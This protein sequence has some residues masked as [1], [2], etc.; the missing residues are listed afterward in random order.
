M[1]PSEVFIESLTIRDSLKNTQ[2]DNTNTIDNQLLP[3]LPFRISNN[4]KLIILGQDPAV[5]NAKSRHSIEYTLNLDKNGALKS[6]IEYICA[7]LS[8]SLENIY[9]TNLFKYFYSKP[10]A[11]TPAVL[12][13]H[14]LPN[15]ELLKKELAGY[16]NVPVITLGEPVLQLLTDDTN[17]VKSF[18]GYNSKTKN[19]NNIFS[20]CGASFNIIKRDFFPF[21]HQPSLRK[22]FYK[23]T[24]NQYLDFMKSKL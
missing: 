4:I 17:F 7:S 16:K 8:I 22:D 19:T 1:K 18:W 12:K 9:A 14:L 2:D 10:P 15:L 21:P 13:K 24:L 23:N 6:Y 3:V 5:K 11:E 20:L